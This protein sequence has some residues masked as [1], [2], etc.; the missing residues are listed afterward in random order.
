MKSIKKPP[1]AGFLDKKWIDFL[2][3]IF[4]CKFFACGTVGIFYNH[5]YWIYCL[6]LIIYMNIFTGRV[7]HT[8]DDV[9]VD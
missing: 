1:A 4:Y 7:L 9:S 2:S 6:L 5:M 3:K 8:L